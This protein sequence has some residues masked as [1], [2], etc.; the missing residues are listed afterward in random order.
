MCHYCH[1]SGHVR[2]D[3]RKLQSG[4]RRFQCS[5]ESLKDGSTPSTMLARSG[6]PN[7][8]PISYSSKW[9]IDSGATYHMTCNSSLFTTFQPHLS[10]STLTLQ[11]GQHLM[12]LG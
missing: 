2:R 11:M 3:C 7:T 10:T 6:K 8:R 4:N 9:V 5:H 1:N 12:S